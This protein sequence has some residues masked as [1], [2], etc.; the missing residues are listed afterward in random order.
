MQVQELRD[1]IERI[2][3][4]PSRR[5]TRMWARGS[6]DTSLLGHT[7]ELELATRERLVLDEGTEQLMIR[8]ASATIEQ[9]LAKIGSL[10][11]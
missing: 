10:V 6:R 2:K 7:Y 1:V 8:R 4:D 11:K 5:H 3:A 9:V